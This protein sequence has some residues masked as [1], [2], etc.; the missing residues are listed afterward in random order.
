MKNRLPF[1]FLSGTIFI[2]CWGANCKS[3]TNHYEPTYSADTS[4]QNILFGVPS[5]SYYEVTDL[6][7]S[8]LNDHL[9]GVRVQAVASPSFV[10][11][12]EKLDQ[13]Y[14]DFTIV[15]GMQAL[16]SAR[17]TYT[18]IG[19][20]MDERGNRG[21]IIVNKDSSI[22]QI[23]DLRGK[24]VASPGPPAVPGHMLQIVYLNNNG[25]DVNKDIKIH[26]AESFESVYLNIY[27][28]KCSAGF[29]TST[30]WFGFV[31]ERPE[32]AAKLL[33]KWET[34]AITGNAVIIRNN[35]DKKTAE[36]IRNLILTMHQNDQGKKA[37]AKIGFRSFHPADSN[38]YQSVKDFLKEYSAV[39]SKHKP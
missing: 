1:P 39:T 10:A 18:I 5:Q 4:T 30:R 36:K 25:I 35:M 15:S 11:F 2:L 17:R 16:E 3:R 31:K 9:K 38:S 7:V 26:Y 37:L 6:F 32:I 21:A 19:Q 29:S 13:D 12:N 8:Y 24:T 28:G 27:L 34:P 14:Y 23:A 22:N 33:L 20:A